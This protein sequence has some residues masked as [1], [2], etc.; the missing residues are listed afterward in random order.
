MHRCV[1]V[2]AI[3]WW[4]RLRAQLIGHHRNAKIKVLAVREEMLGYTTKKG[5]RERGA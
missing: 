4:R 3:K 2:N 1:A 5:L